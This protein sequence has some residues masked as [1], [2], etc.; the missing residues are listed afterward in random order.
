MRIDT[1]PQAFELRRIIA[2]PIT[3]FAVVPAAEAGV[4]ATMKALA[5][6]ANAALECKTM[7]TLSAALLALAVTHRH[8]ARQFGARW[9]TQIERKSERYSGA[10]LVN[11]SAVDQRMA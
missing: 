7:P 6:L 5:A 9:S 3:V 8:G 10:Q 11:R 2:S 4:H 1:A